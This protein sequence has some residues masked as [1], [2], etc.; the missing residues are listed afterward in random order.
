MALTI[1]QQDKEGITLLE[2]QGNLTFGEECDAFN[3]QIKDLLE[4]NR[5]RIVLNMEG[6]NFCDSSGL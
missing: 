3:Q 1:T 6:I 5:P 4:A 2:L